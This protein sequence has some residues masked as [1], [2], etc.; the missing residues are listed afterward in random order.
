[1]QFGG[2]E[3]ATRRWQGDHDSS[4]EEWRVYSAQWAKNVNVAQWIVVSTYNHCYYY[5][6]Y[7]S[8]IALERNDFQVVF[9][10]SWA[11][12]ATK[13]LTRP[14]VQS[15]SQVLHLCY[16]DKWNDRTMAIMTLYK[17]GAVSFENGMCVRLR[18]CIVIFYC[19]HYYRCNHNFEAYY[20]ASALLLQEQQQS[21]IQ[22]WNP[23]PP[24]PRQQS[25]DQLCNRKP[26]TLLHTQKGTYKQTQRGEKMKVN[27]KSSQKVKWSRDSGLN[28]KKSKLLWLLFWL[29]LW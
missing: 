6:Y 22:N 11:L 10:C 1:M 21:F 14:S 5:Y 4:D 19:S 20:L 16:G 8:R 9:R 26:G 13:P 23:S 15:F 29:L 28:K 24:P 7:Y 25:Y 27:L 18:V 17:P 12:P 3:N 2:G